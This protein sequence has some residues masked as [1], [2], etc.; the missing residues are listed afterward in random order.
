MKNKLKSITLL[1]IAI[2]LVSNASA[3]TGDDSDSSSPEV[4]IEWVTDYSWPY[5]DLPNSDNSAEDFYNT[6]GNAGWTKKFNM[7]NS[8]ASDAHFEH[9]G[10]NGVD[11]SYVDGADIV[12]YQGHGEDDSLHLA[13][14][15]KRV[16]YENEIKWGDYDLEWIALHSC[17]STAEPSNF[18]QGNGPEYGFNGVHLVCGFYTTALNYAEDGGNFADRL[19][20]GETV[21]DAWFHAIDETHGSGRSLRVIG[22][23]SNCRYDHI[24]GEGSV[25]SDPT[26]DG[27]T[28]YWDFD[29]T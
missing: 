14:Y 19:L 4:G 15:T 22:E 11:S 6:L 26:V 2:C 23:S 3:G 5:S 12:F 7:G 10:V 25:I 8:Y 21:K 1:L 17:S 9:S 28:Y 24:W 20:N 29:C 16:I 27:T 13:T 18:I